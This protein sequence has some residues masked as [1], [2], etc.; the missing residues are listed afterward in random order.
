MQCSAVKVEGRRVD[1]LIELPADVPSVDDG[2]IL[3]SLS[4]Y[5]NTNNINSLNHW[6]E[7]I[8]KRF[9]LDQDIE[10]WI[11]FSTNPKWKLLYKKNNQIVKNLSINDSGLSKGLYKSNC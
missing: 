7:Y 3:Y 2:T 11:G 4:T 10:K 1:N 6:M 5:L 9:M 8:N